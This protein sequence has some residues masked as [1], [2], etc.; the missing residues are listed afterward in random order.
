MAEPKAVSLEF[1]AAQMG[2][3]LEEQGSLRDDMAVLLA[4]M[5]RV[6]GTVQGLVGEVRA[7]HSRHARL[8]RR[9]TAL[10]EKPGGP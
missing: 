9:V 6:D 2:R 4:M 1:L 8:E 7:M 3:V 5:Q 10:E